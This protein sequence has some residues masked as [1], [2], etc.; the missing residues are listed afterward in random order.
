MIQDRNPGCDQARKYCRNQDDWHKQILPSF[1]ET[2]MAVDVGIPSATDGPRLTSTVSRHGR[3]VQPAT[4][5]PLERE[6]DPR[7]CTAGGTLLRY[8]LVGNRLW[9]VARK[10]PIRGQNSHRTP[11]IQQRGRAQGLFSLSG[12]DHFRAPIE[13]QLPLSPLHLQRLAFLG[14]T[15]TLARRFAVVDERQRVPTLT[16]LDA[17]F[18]RARPQGGKDGVPAHAPEPVPRIPRVGL[19]PVHYGVPV[20]SLRGVEILRHAVRLVP[21]RKVEIQP[22]QP[23][24]MQPRGL[25]QP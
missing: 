5:G 12:I 25:Q 9:L 24:R 8:G 16:E 7:N 11:A 2:W 21:A 23:R 3:S 17:D 22:R 1:N 20:A 15:R 4:D 6:V 10:L 19:L 13:E 14:R 18:R